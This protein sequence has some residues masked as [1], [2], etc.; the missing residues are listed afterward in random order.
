MP[1]SPGLQ[2]VFLGGVLY[3][4]DQ[5]WR[6]GRIADLGSRPSPD[7]G[8]P[9]GARIENYGNRCRFVDVPAGGIATRGEQARRSPDIG[10]RR[11]AGRFQ[12]V[13]RIG[14]HGLRR[15]RFVDNLVDEA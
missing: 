10:G 12:R 11:Y 14:C 13:E 4:P 9:P 6:V 2:H 7:M 8:P 1:C 15:Q 3:M 5:I